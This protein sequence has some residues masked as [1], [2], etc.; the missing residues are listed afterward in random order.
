MSHY[1]IGLTIAF[2][3]DIPFGPDTFPTLAG[4]VAEIARLAKAQWLAYAQGEPLPNGQIIN[5]RSGTYH[6][7]IT[8]EQTGPLAYRIQSRLPYAEAIETGS[9]ARDLK[10][11]L[12]SSLKVRVS[13]DGKRYLIIPFRHGTPGT[14]GFGNNV[15]PQAVHDFWKPQSVARSRVISLGTRPAGTGASDIKTRQTVLVP[16]RNYAWGERLTQQHLGAMGIGGQA[17]K[18]MAG[19]VNFRNPGGSGGAA[20]SQYLTFRAMTEDSP[21]WKAPAIPGKYPAKI[22]AEQ[23]KPIAER[24]FK[25]ALENDIRNYFGR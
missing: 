9:P 16:Q 7:S 20:H 8:L 23:F 18:R 15:M 21:G 19:M 2:P 4:A 17:A 6:H 3:P 13:K 11:M 5:A 1:D 10:Q 12:H 14:V 22:T 25:Q 24:A